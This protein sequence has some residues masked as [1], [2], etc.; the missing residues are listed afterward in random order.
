MSF[1]SADRQPSASRGTGHVVPQDVDL[2]VVRHELAQL[3]VGVVDEAL[4]GGGIG[5]GQSP[6]GM[7]PIHERVIKTDAHIFRARRFH[8]FLHQIA[9]GAQLRAQ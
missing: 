3:A 2:A 5:F 1:I 6:I 8:I 7:V 9:A 4:P